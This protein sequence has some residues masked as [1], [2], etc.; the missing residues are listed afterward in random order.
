[1][2]LVQKQK[3]ERQECLSP[4]DRSCHHAHK[5]KVQAPSWSLKMGAYI[6]NP[7]EFTTAFEVKA[8]EGIV[9][10]SEDRGKWPPFVALRKAQSPTCS[11]EIHE[12]LF[13]LTIPSR[14]IW[15]P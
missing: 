2:R 11:G 13:K 12:I 1:M 10:L 14:T 4:L 15:Q 3:Q 5:K 8:F 7:R 9:N 6:T